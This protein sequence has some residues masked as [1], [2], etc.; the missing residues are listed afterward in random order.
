M[1]KR[2]TIKFNYCKD[3]MPYSNM[4][5]FIVFIDHFMYTVYSD[6]MRDEFKVARNHATYRDREVHSCNYL[7]DVII[8]TTNFAMCKISPT[9]PL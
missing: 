9:T 5:N 7:R 6:L 4:L 1:I 8:V 2:L 3:F